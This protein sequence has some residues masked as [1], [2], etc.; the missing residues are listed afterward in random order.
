MRLRKERYLTERGRSCILGLLSEREY[1]FLFLQLVT[2]TL[3]KESHKSYSTGE[4]TE[5]YTCRTNEPKQSFSTRLNLFCYLV[6]LIFYQFFSLKLTNIF[7]VIILTTNTS[8]TRQCLP[9]PLQVK[10]TLST[11]DMAL[12]QIPAFLEKEK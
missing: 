9:P 4:A 6:C 8:F 2:A 12:F 10:L 5:E 7:T 3:T 1:C 11:K